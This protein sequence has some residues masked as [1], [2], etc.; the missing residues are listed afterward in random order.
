MRFRWRGY[1][2]PSASGRTSSPSPP[3]SRCAGP[4]A[5][6]SRYTDSRASPSRSA[7][8]VPQRYRDLPSCDAAYLEDEQLARALA[9]STEDAVAMALVASLHLAPPAASAPRRPPAAA[10]GGGSTPTEARQ[11]MEC[12]VC[13]EDLSADACAVFTLNNKRVCP[14]VLHHHCALELPHKLCPLCRTEFGTAARVP[15]LESDPEGWF[16][17]L[18]LEGEDRLDK[19]QVMQV[20]LTQFSLDVLKFEASLNELWPTFDTE[21]TGFITREA[22]F[23]PGRG[24]LDYARKNLADLSTPRQHAG[25]LPDIREDRLQW[26]D[27]FDEDEAGALTQE[28]LVRAL[29][30]TYNL[31]NDL[32][33]VHMMRELVQ[34]V[35]GI[36][37]ADDE[38]KISRDAFLRPGDGLADTIIA[39]LAINPPVAPPPATEAP[40]DT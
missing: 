2:S 16:R 10:H 21:G 7:A 19:A 6:P 4:R 30:K 12:A 13:F 11:L 9:E 40:D 24:L 8:R 17:L 20:L 36:F 25:E 14:H 34:A 18:C 38:T 15:K 27:R 37:S 1:R 35:W 28:Q 5:S 29:I 32:A 33:Q 23:A 31:S 26:F 3:Q 22:F 39:G